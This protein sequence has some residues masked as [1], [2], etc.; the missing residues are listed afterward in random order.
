MDL[1]DDM[2]YLKRY[3]QSHPNNRMAWYLL[4]KQ[5]MQEEK[6][7]KANY[8][9][10][11]SG[12]I[13]D[14][15]ERKQHP[16]A[17]E[18]KQM[19][20]A[21]NR[22]RRSRMLLMRTTAGLL[23]I[24]A[25]TLILPL[26]KKDEDAKQGSNSV[27]SEASAD[28]VQTSDESPGLAVMF[29]KPSGGG[30]LGKA[31]GVLLKGSGGGAKIGLAVMLEQ[32]GPWRKWTGD[33]RIVVQTQKQRDGQADVSLLDAKTCDCQ[34]DDASAAFKTYTAWSAQQEMQWTLA[35]GIVQYRERTKSWPSGLEALNKP[36]P[37]N[38]LSGSSLAMKQLFPK[39]LRQLKSAAAGGKPGDEESGS[40]DASPTNTNKPG[41]S[42]ASG[43]PASESNQLPDEPLSIIIDKDTHQLAVVSGDVI[44][45]SYTVGLGGDKTPAGSFAITEKVRNPNGQDDSE[46][47][48][49]GMTLSSTL[50]A[51]HGTNDPDSIGKDESHGCVRM[52]R[53]D[54]EELFDLV[55][56]GTKVKI[57]SGVLPAKTAPI[58]SR[59]RLQPVQ[60]ETNSAVVYRW[61]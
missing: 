54:L 15:Y 13:Y 16:L 44:V 47:G 59:F 22:K 36:Y 32:D 8:C 42:A 29:V 2:N 20:A 30:T 49:R 24:L 18:P 7:A 40:Q 58:A 46:F 6:E 1:Q 21:W 60:D 31:L 5:Y 38:I 34:P 4:G 52:L 39:L 9:F 26:S 45:R 27:Q 55:P 41:S 3:V 50:Y 14:A 61:L 51:I 25:L 28:P 35:S 19:I 48:S 12:S 53:K 57:K 23:A 56:L 10:L 43:G 17:S 33:T 37:N 11:Q